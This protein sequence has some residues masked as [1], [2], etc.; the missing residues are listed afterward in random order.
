MATVLIAMV[1]DVVTVIETS[2]RSYALRR[3][4]WARSVLV[5]EKIL[6]S[7]LCRRILSKL[8]TNFY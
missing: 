2:A 3:W 5:M 7:D 6:S 4:M 1:E 8:G